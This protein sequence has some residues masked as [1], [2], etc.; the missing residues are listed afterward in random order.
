LQRAQYGEQPV[1]M[2]LTLAAMLGQIGL[3]GGGYTYSLG[4]LAQVGQLPPR[5][6]V[7]GLPQRQNP[8]GSYIPVARIADMLL[9]PAT[10]YDFDGE[11][12]V[13]PDIKL[14]YWVGGNPFHHHQDLHR[15]TA[16][17]SRPETFVVHEPYW[18]PTARFADIVLPSTITLERNDIGG[19]SEDAHVFAMQQAVAPFGQAR[20][21]YAIFSGLAERL[22]VAEPFTEGRTPDGWLRHIYAGLAAQLERIGETPPSF[23]AFWEQGELILPTHA[24][25]DA[26]LRRFRDDPE[27]ARLP[28][29]SG[30]IEIFSETIAGFGY[31]DCPGHPTWLE[32]DEWLGSPLA[33]RYPL[34]LVANQPASR[35]HS[36]LDFGAHSQDTKSVGREVLRIHP[37]DA[38]V[39]GIRDEDVVK[40]FSERGACLVVAR[41]TED[42]RPGVVQLPTGAWFDPV[43]IT[44][45]DRPVCGAGN[46]NMVTRD[47]GTS[48]LAQGCTG[49][50]CLVQVERFDGDVPPGHGYDPPAVSL[51]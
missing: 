14:V 16:A 7:P 32:P 27:G 1:W 8:T 50:L 49:Q 48:K 40:V 6:H 44:G 21:E 11:R 35:L 20:D 13:Y 18:T 19:S 22:G 12:R 34:Q 5:V 43:R 46:P 51:L 39:R 45:E 25:P 26:W 17:L 2:G 23:D 30:K 4:A 29:P 47:I 33:E 28:T 42:V 9:H 36:Q 10:E 31:D 38:G 3:P 37:A 15:L 24:D 41:L